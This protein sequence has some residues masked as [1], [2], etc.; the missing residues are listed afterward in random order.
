MPRRTL[1][2]RVF[3]NGNSQAVRIPGPFRLDAAEV[4]ITRDDDGT[5]TIRPVAPLRGQALLDALG[6]FD[7]AYVERLE[8]ARAEAWPMQD[9][10]RP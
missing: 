10:E 6:G 3:A 1:R 5:L 8:A 9:R 7:A 2:S 4:E